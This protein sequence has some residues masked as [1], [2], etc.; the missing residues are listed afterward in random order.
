MVCDIPGIKSLLIVNVL[1]DILNMGFWKKIIFVKHTVYMCI[2]Y[3][4]VNV[5]SMII[6][7]ENM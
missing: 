4:H 3:M 1:N 5:F 7:N 6:T 2:S